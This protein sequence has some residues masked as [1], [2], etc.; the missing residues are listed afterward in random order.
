MYLYLMNNMFDVNMRWDQPG[1]VRF[2]YSL[3]S[4]AGDWREG[5]ADQ[6]G[7]DNLNPLIAEVAPGKNEGRTARRRAV[8]CDRSAERRLH[9]PQAGRGQRRRLHRAVRRD[10]GPGDH[11][12][13]VA[14][15]PA[16][17]YPRPRKRTSSK[18]TRTP[19]SRGAPNGNRVAVTLAPFGVTTIR[20]TCARRPPAVSVKAEARVGHGS[21]AFL[22]DGS[23]R[24]GTSISHYH[25]YRGTKPDFKPGLLNLVERPRGTLV[26]GSSAAALRRLDQQ[27]AGARHDVLLPRRRG[28]SLEQRRPRLAS[29]EL[30][31]R[32][33]RAKRTCGRCKVECLRAIPVSPI[34]RFNVVNLLWRTSCESD[35]RRYEVYR[36]TSPGA[37]PSAAT[38]IATVD[39]DEVIKGGT[40]YG[41]TPL[42]H[43]AGEY[44]HMMYLDKTVDPAMT[45]YYRVAAIDDDAQRGAFSDEASVSTEK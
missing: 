20:V 6:F 22:A 12:D 21:G 23:G 13:R 34:S 11:D 37:M 31:P 18:T 14:P 3:R 8:S 26:H 17:D 7:W 24:G 44:D 25:V 35:V 29:R 28:G 42:D 45:Y 2:T 33:R 10:P 43:R 41:Q 9:H 16:A 32:C 4:H 38:R 15:V 1:P 27:P 40:G 39:A 30:P 19:G 36:F 5:K